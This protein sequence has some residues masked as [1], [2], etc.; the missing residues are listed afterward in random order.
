LRWPGSWSTSALL[1][2]I[3]G[4]CALTGELWATDSMTDRNWHD[5]A[6]TGKPATLVGLVV[7]VGFLR[8]PHAFLNRCA[9][10]PRLVCR[11]DCYRAAPAGDHVDAAKTRTY[12]ACI[13]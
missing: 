1:R 7:L 8:M 6:V 4:R 12:D 5:L 11:T 9:C 13:Q 3:P 10:S 2:R